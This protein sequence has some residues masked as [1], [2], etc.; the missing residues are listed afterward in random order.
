MDLYVGALLEPPIKGAVVGL[1]FRDMIADQ[2]SRL[3]KGDRYFYNLGPA[4]N[5]GA[6][7]SGK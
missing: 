1:T 3:K 7:S 2:F 4:I 5:P 6:F